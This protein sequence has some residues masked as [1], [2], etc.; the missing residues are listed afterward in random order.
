MRAPDFWERRNWLA[1]SLAP[2]GCAYAAAGWLRKALIRP[3]E[4]GAP[5]ICV[6]NVVAGGAGKTPT[7]LAIA[8]MLA[9]CKP[10]ALS[11]GYRCRLKGPVRVDP[12]AH[13]SA[14][15]GDEPLLLAAQL[16]SW[17]ARDRLAGTRT[18]AE[19]GAGLII[20][21][22]GFQNPALKKA[23]SVLV[24]D[25]VQG[26]GNGYCLPAGP[27]RE[28]VSRALGRADAVLVI[29]P[30][31]FRPATSKPVF[32]A[33]I[34]PAADAMSFSGKRV[35]AFAGIGRPKKF[36]D[37]LTGGGAE[38]IAAHAFADHHRFAEAELQRMA[39]GTGGDTILVTTEKDHVRL[40]EAW[41]ERVQVLP[42]ELRFDDRPA[43]ERFL[44]KRLEAA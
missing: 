23:V 30:G 34:L 22:D 14:D 17:V 40:P 38:L 9:D 7:V 24:V 41:R 32:R 12:A 35:V 13:H 36:F 3:Q 18:A 5:V 6:G 43:L 16:P 4:T 28:P 2:A 10:H 37:T 20:M 25:S 8:A 31:A 27:L 44:R 39:V 1:G 15:V 33:R 11:R 29:G 26:F 42:V 19:A 21:D